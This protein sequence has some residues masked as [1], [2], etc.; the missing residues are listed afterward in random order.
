[1]S[2]QKKQ[3]IS[4]WR[5]YLV[6]AVLCSLLAL[7]VGRVLSLQVLDME[8]GHEFLQDQGAMRSVRTVSHDPPPRASTP[9]RPTV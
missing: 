5:F 6:V 3:P 4:V 9:W 8:R 2:R 7:L 1:M